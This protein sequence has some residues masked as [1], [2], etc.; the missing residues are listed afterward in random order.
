MFPMDRERMTS[1]ERMK[2][3]LTGQKPDRVPFVPFAYGFNALI[4]GYE[5]GDYY[6]DPEKSFRAQMLCKE[7]LAHDGNPLFSYA[8]FGAWEFGGKIRP[9]AGNCWTDTVRREDFILSSP[10]WRP[11]WTQEAWPSRSLTDMA[12]ASFTALWKIIG[13]PCCTPV[14]NTCSTMRRSG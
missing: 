2:A 11:F 14:G 10:P 12:T 13:A 5:I 8:S 9:I 1:A 3:V 4:A 7:I 6:S